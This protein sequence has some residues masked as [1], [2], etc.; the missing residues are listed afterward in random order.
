MR[1]SIYCCDDLLKVRKTSILFKEIGL[2]TY[3][4]NKF[5][6]VDI[7]NFAFGRKAK[8]LN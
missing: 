1:E 6:D 2:L 7:E 4:K 3:I 5:F 8:C